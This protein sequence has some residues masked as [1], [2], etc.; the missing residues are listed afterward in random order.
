MPSL[1]AR[2]VSKKHCPLVINALPIDSIPHPRALVVTSPKVSL[3]APIVSATLLA[4]IVSAAL[5]A[6]ATGDK[7]QPTRPRLLPSRDSSLPLIFLRYPGG[8]TKF[9]RGA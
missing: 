5:L 2:Y 8:V 9:S 1:V 4:P 7:D 6:P 3:H